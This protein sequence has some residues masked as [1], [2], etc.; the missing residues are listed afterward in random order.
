[1]KIKTITLTLGLMLAFAS[2]PGRASMV[3]TYTG[4]EFT[5]VKGAF[6]TSDF[7]TA[8]FSLDDALAANTSVDLTT[9]AGFTLTMSAGHISMTNTVG[10]V[11]LTEADVST[12]AFGNIV[13]WG[14][15]FSELVN[16]DTQRNSLLTRHFPGYNLDVVIDRVT[17]GEPRGNEIGNGSVGPAGTWTSASVVPIP[18]AA[19][20][21]GSGLLGLIGIARR[22]N[23]R[24]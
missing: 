22:K 9:L 6:E 20:L 5:S 15:G 19:W 16:N 11:T 23:H 18:A 2:V 10:G 7:F 13:T 12:D 14:L 3:Y 4:L 24:S 21:F 1:M 17:L 8:T